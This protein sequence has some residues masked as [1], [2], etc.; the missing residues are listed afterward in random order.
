MYMGKP[1]LGARDCPELKFMWE[2]AG[3]DHAVAVVPT[4][5][6]TSN[7]TIH[8]HLVFINRYTSI[9]AEEDGEIAQEV[10]M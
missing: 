5:D 2:I 1:H 4:K 3:R 6:G 8:V 7:G 9:R 10:V